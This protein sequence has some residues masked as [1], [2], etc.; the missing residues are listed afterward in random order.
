MIVALHT[1]IT[2]YQPSIP[3]T[4]RRPTA[5][6]GPPNHTVVEHSDTQDALAHSSVQAHPTV[7]TEVKPSHE[8]PA[9]I[10]ETGPSGKEILLVVGTDGKSHR[11]EGM[12]QM[13]RDNRKQY[14]DL[15][16]T[17]LPDIVDSRIRSYVG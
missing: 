1:L 15:H 16:G 13:V 5:D 2:F 9:T 7:A 8:T 14:V 11:I 3:T 6:K 4:W 17:L 12:E 10:Q